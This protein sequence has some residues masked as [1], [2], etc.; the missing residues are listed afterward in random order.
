MLWIGVVI[1]FISWKPLGAPPQAYNLAL[2]ILVILVILLQAAFTAVQ[3][4]SSQKVMDSILNL[5]P[6]SAVVLR[7]GRQT[8][9]P[10]SELV[11]GDIVH[12][13]V[14]NRVPADMRILEASPDLKFDRSVLTGEVEE[15]SG[16]VETKE[17]NYLE[18]QNIALLGTHVT[19]GSATCIVVLTGGRTLMGRINKLTSATGERRTNLQREITRFVYIIITITVSIIIIMV[20]VWAAWLRV[21]HFDYLNVPGFLTDVMGLVVAFI[22]EGMPIAVALTLSLIARRMRDVNILPKTLSAVETLGCVNVV[23]SDKTGTLTENKMS[24]VSI[25]FVDR[26][27]ALPAEAEDLKATKGLERTKFAMAA[28]N[29]SV[30]ENA[31]EPVEQWIIQG[32]ATD[33][34]CLRYAH[35][36]DATSVQKLYNLPFNSRNKYMVTIVHSG[37]ESIMLV[38][39][40]LRMYLWDYVPTT[41]IPTARAFHSIPKPPVSWSHDRNH[42]LIKVN[43]SSWLLNDPSRLPKPSVRPSS[44]RMSRIPSEISLY[45]ASLAFSILLVSIR[46]T[47]CR[48][49]VEV[50]QNSS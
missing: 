26:G 24:V 1:F 47:Q 16:L 12:L 44:N 46:P 20:I 19:N 8:S 32:N 6:E 15:V 41:L 7:D 27:F 11:T 43:E 9:I 18:A 50:A 35:D 2:A 28:C 29:D 42:G 3:D 25:G 36:V 33:A 31:S 48:N 23:C 17:P 4:W 5:V 45:L 37:K 34:A 38:K 39:G 49:V 30:L 21:D 10:S 40:A 14:G 13:T 22:P